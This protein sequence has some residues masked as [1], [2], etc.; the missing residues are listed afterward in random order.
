L[1]I[2][3]SYD[4]LG[5]DGLAHSLNDGKNEAIF[6]SC[7]LLK[8]MPEVA[9]QVDSLKFVVYSN[10]FACTDDVVDAI[11]KEMYAARGDAVEIHSLKELKA[12]CLFSHLNCYSWA[13]KTD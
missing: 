5:V 2:S 4:T 8:I 11:K 1:T 12:V 3:T 6:T 10:T 13:R 7:D 9:K